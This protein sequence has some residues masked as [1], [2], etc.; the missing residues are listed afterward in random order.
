MVP[1]PLVTEV[2]GLSDANLVF[3][4]KGG[5]KGLLFVRF[6]P[7]GLPWF[8]LVPAL[9]SQGRWKEMMMSS[10]SI[11]KDQVGDQRPC[12]ISGDVVTSGNE[13]RKAR[14]GSPV[15]PVLKGDL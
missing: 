13:I 8:M 6:H 5:W 15:P 3:F 12:R 1:F 9:P 14:N 10:P 11:E 4:E 2:E 7:V